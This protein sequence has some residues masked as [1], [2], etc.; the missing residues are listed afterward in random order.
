MTDVTY[1]G[2]MAATASHYELGRFW[3]NYDRGKIE[4][5]CGASFEALLASGCDN[6]RASELAIYLGQIFQHMGWYN[7]AIAWFER[8]LNGFGD[9]LSPVAG[10]QAQLNIAWC[11]RHMDEFDSALLHVEKSLVQSTAQGNLPGRA[12]ALSIKGICLWHQHNV[13]PSLDCLGEA[14]RIF[15]HVNDYRG[16]ADAQTISVLSIGAWDSMKRHS[17]IFKLLFIFPGLGDRKGQ[18]KCANSL[19]T[20]YW[21]S[22]QIKK[23]FAAYQ[24]ADRINT[25]IHQ[26]YILGLTANNLGRMYLDQSEFQKAIDAFEH[27]RSIRQALGIESYEMIDV[28]GLARA[29]FHLGDLGKA[30]ELSRLAICSLERHPQVE[31]L[32]WAYYN[33]Y[34]IMNSGSDAGRAEGLLSLA[35]AR[36][37][38]NGSDRH[39]L[40]SDGSH[41]SAATSTDGAR[42]HSWHAAGVF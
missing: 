2:R 22:G 42:H 18:G 29:W 17:S 34:V 28:S 35:K 6:T 23:A 12:A 7:A 38:V 8:A 32:P 40:R 27:A 11:L 24:E 14:E 36:E 37:L 41:C 1:L 26:P 16:K 19:G 4:K 30:V 39:N 10:A 15:E 25:E 20:T 5:A 33:H 9:Q 31:D 21:W 3:K 13:S